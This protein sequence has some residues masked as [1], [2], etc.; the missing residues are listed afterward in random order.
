MGIFTQ[1]ALTIKK[2]ENIFPQ[3]SPFVSRG[4]AYVKF[5]IYMPLH[6]PLRL[7]LP[8]GAGTNLFGFLYST[9]QD[10]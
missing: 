9:Y 10:Y 6:R 4:M 2:H 3:V 7:L 1:K 5:S 8:T